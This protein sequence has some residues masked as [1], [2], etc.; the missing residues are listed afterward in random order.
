[1]SASAF[2][3][4]SGVATDFATEFGRA[5][6]GHW[7]APGRVNL[8]GEHVDY[9][10]GLCL[11]FAIAERTVVEVAARDD[12]RMRLHSLAEDGGWEGT[13]ADVAP[14]SPGG[15]AGYVAGVLWALRER[16]PRG[17]DLLV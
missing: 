9:A 3:E 5:P 16:R 4:A 1:M 14:G 13:L 7:A 17:I 8:I 15:W 2:P 6:A 11:P 12:N 10:Q